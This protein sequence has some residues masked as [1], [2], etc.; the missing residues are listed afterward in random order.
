LLIIVAKLISESDKKLTDIEKTVLSSIKR[1][2]LFGPI[3]DQDIFSTIGWGRVEVEQVI[4]LL[5]LKK[6]IE[7]YP[8]ECR[9]R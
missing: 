5:V 4:G 3:I 1:G 6:I 9:E 7:G 2:L 8:Q